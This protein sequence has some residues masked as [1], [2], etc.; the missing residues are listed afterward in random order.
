MNLLKSVARNLIFPI[1][2]GLGVEK[3][4]SAFSNN[5]CQVLVYHGVVKNK[6][7]ALSANHCSVKEFEKEISYLS[8]NFS[9]VSLTDIFKLHRK[10][11]R[12]SK[13]TI[14]ITFD[15]GYENNYT[16]AFP[17]LKKYNVP[18][19]IFVV[20]SCVTN[21]EHILWYDYVD[22]NKEYI[23][24]SLFPAIQTDLSEDELS[25]VKKIQNF[26]NL[27]S[28]LKSVN[29]ASKLKVLKEIIPS[30]QAASTISRTNSEFRKMLSVAQMKEMTDSGLIEIGSHSLTHPNLDMLTETELVFEL[31]ESKKLL[32]QA[33]GKEIV[34]IAFPDGAYNE[35]VKRL[36]YKAGYRQLLS[37]ESRLKSDQEDENILERFCISNTTTPESN[38][39]QVQL[40]FNRWGF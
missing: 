6:N 21:P 30:G 12:P 40:G 20:A 26:S 2:T 17:V 38:M 15:D 37:V 4:A 39:I 7:L 18:A 8:K 1:A 28:F 3:L 27:R 25:R 16:N 34:S 14:A 5:Q 13:K 23:D 19:T 24:F 29:T 22:I 36:S 11:I 33:T 10:K 9:I 35:E 31:N 32:E